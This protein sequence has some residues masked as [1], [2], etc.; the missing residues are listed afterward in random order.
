MFGFTEWEDFVDA[1]N[2]A[3]DNCS[4]V[5]TTNDYDGW[6]IGVYLYDEDLT[7]LLATGEKF[8]VVFSEDEYCWYVNMESDSTPTIDFG[9][10]D[11]SG[12]TIGE[13]YP[14]VSDLDTHSSDFYDYGFGS[15]YAYY[16]NY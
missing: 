6:T 5:Y 2:T 12:D 15:W 1:C 14:T 9:W 8:G 13:D 11:V 10:D 16:S 4:D 3:T 7:D